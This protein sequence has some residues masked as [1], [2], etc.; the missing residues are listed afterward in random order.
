[1]AGKFGI[2]QLGRSPNCYYTMRWFHSYC[3]SGKSALGARAE[4]V[5]VMLLFLNYKVVSPLVDPSFTCNLYCSM[6]SQ[7]QCV[8]PLTGLVYPLGAS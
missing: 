1:M 8:E 3:A 5:L 4:D 6:F 2:S 7:F